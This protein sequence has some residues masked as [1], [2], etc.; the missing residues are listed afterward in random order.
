MDAFCDDESGLFPSARHRAPGRNRPAFQQR[1]HTALIVV[2]R[3]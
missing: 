2:L 1:R 3:P